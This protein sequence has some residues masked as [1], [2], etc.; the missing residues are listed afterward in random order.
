M[1]EE[2]KETTQLEKTDETKG[3]NAKRMKDRLN[4]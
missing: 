3:R 2:K 1:N 4:E